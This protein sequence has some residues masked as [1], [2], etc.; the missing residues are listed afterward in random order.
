MTAG[1]RLTSVETKSADRVNDGSIHA[2]P[3]TRTL[4]VT[5]STIN[6]LTPSSESVCPSKYAVL[7]VE[8]TRN[9]SLR[10]PAH[11]LRQETARRN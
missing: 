5:L 11:S 9:A 7:V 4:L 3:A 6:T 10:V 8:S 1:D 2:V